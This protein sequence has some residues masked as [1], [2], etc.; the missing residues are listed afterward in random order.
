[1]AN[2]TFR[3]DPDAVR[4]F[5]F[6]WSKYLAPTDDTISSAS[7]TVDAG[8]TKGSVSTTTTTVTVW[9]SGGSAD[10]SYD[11]ACEVTTAAGVVDERTVVIQVDHL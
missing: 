2:A 4:P 8:L 1:M 6:D 5:K 7:V 10:T 3:K 9:L 11:V